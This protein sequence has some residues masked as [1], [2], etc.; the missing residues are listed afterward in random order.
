MPA[1]RSI[2]KEDSDEEELEAIQAALGKV[3][4]LEEDIRNRTAEYEKHLRD[5]PG[6]IDKWLEYSKLHLQ[7][8]SEASVSSATVD[9]A[10]QPTNRANAEVTL[11]IL[12]RALEHQPNFSSTELHIAY[13]RT[14]EVFWPTNKVTERWQNV[15]RTLGDRGASEEDMMGLYLGYIEWREGQG[16]GQTAQGSTGGVDEVV[17]VYLDCLYKLNT[18]R[19][20]LRG[21]DYITDISSR[22][23]GA[24]REP[25]ISP[26]PGVLVPQAGG[27]Q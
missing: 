4:T 1:Y 24:R 13:L 8:H 23:G 14:A 26:P 7:L 20:E 21:T 19:G 18:G 6:D 3:S 22:P 17:D 15:I 2:A 16:I 9:P 5:Y 12:S 27:I 25:G 11:S 10:K